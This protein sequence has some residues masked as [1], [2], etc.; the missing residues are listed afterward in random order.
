MTTSAFMEAGEKIY[1]SIAQIF[2]GEGAITVDK[3]HFNPYLKLTFVEL[4]LQNEGV[5]FSIA[6][7][8]NFDSHPMF[9][10]SPPLESTLLHPTI[11]RTYLQNG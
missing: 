1:G 5:H 9:S 3:H 11:A 4:F 10:S 8:Q 6:F 2:H 7:K